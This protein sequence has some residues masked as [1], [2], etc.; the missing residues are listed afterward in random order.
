MYIKYNTLLYYTLLCNYISLLVIIIYLINFIFNSLKMLILK[1]RH[2]TNKTGNG[3]GKMEG[4]MEERGGGGREDYCTRM[5]LFVSYVTG[6]KNMR[7][8][9]KVSVKSWR[10]LDYVWKHQKSNQENR[11]LYCSVYKKT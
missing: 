7:R 1:Y 2:Y 6:Q 5:S 11:L 10:M 8:R 3:E 9:F 4:G